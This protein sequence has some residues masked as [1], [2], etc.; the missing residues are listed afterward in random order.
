MAASTDTRVARLGESLSP[1]ALAAFY[2]AKFRTEGAL[3]LAYRGAILIWLFAIITQ[4]LISI[5]VWRTVARSQGGSAGGFTE[6]EYA[7]YFIILMVVNQLTFSWHMWEMGW[8]VQSGQFS[9]TLLRPM[10]PIHNDIVENMV[11]KALTLVPLAPVVV[12]FSV[13]FEAEYDWKAP[14][15]LALG[16]AIVLAALLLFLMEWTIGL[17]AFWITKTNALFQL[18]SSVY[19]FLTGF[20][21]PLALLP[22]PARILA[23][24]LPFRWVL[25]FPV[26]M[27]RGASGGSDIAIGF[28][29]QL[30][31]IGIL[32]GM[33]RLVWSHAVSRY[34]A[35]GA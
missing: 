1:R 16:P 21:A 6:G 4:P 13:I 24:I 29:M 19:F 35:V 2:S 32:L 33:L 10:H 25:S 22:E 14:N 5:V 28:G 23:S 26:E 20:I 3:Q 8:R 7:A 12:I 27:A 11:F 34:S 9:G 18:Y 15:L 30:L 31:W 17:L